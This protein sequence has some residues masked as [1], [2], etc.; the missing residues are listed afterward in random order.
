[1]N[2]LNGLTY[3]NKRRIFHELDYKHNNK[4]SKHTKY[5]NTIKTIEELNDEER[6]NMLQY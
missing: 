2:K 6:L 5:N 4:R 1:M 3:V